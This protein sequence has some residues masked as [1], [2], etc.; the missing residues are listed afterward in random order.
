MQMTRLNT[1]SGYIPSYT[2]T[3]LT[4]TLHVTFGFRTDYEFITKSDMR[5]IVKDT[6]KIPIKKL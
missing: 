3:K 1:A 4:D 5:T 6:K 2:R